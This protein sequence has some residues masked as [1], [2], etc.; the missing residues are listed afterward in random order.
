MP[1]VFTSV[2]SNGDDRGDEEIVSALGAAGAAVPRGAVADAEVDEVEVGIVGDGIPNSAAASQ[3]AR[4]PGPRLCSFFE[5][6]RFV[7]LRRIAGDGVEAPGHFSS[8]GVIGGDVTA[9][10]EFRAT[11]A[12]QNF[13]FD[14]ARRSGDGVGIFR[15]DR[16]SFPDRFSGGGLERHKAAVQGT[17]ENFSLPNSNAAIDDV[18]A[19]VDGPFGRDFGIV[20]PNF[21]SSCGFHGEDFAPGG[22]EVH[23]AIDHDGGGFL[24]AMSV[25]VNVPG[26]GELADILVIDLL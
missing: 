20:G 13:A 19:G 12:D 10:A 16:E 18:T 11:V 17:N 7:G 2:G 1:D 8:C 3:L 4:L 6:G 9:H 21:F 15:I 14:D 5:N 26:E 24:A 23:H 25:Q 22:G